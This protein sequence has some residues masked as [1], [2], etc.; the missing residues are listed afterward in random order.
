MDEMSDQPSQPP[1]TDTPAADYLSPFFHALEEAARQAL[2]KTGERVNALHQAIEEESAQVIGQL[3]GVLATLER[4]FSLEGETTQTDPQH[5]SRLAEVVD[6][7]SNLVFRKIRPAM[8]RRL[9]TVAPRRGP[10]LAA[11]ELASRGYAE[12]ARF[13]PEEPQP[14]SPTLEKRLGRIPGAR[15]FLDLLEVSPRQ[16]YIESLP[17]RESLTEHP[18]VRNYAAAHEKAVTQ[19]A[20][21]WRGLRF[22][23]DLASE[24]IFALTEA[25]APREEPV[26]TAAVLADC[27]TLLV[28]TCNDAETKLIAGRN[29]L[30]E[31]L[32]ALPGALEE[33]NRNFIDRIREEFLETR[34]W[35][36]LRRH[37]Q[38]QAR[39]L[40]ADWQG[41]AMSLIDQGKEEVSRSAAGLSQNTNLL[42]NVQT[43]L[44]KGGRVQETFLALTDLPGKETLLEKSAS[45]PR[46]YQ[47]LFTLGPLR[48]REFLVAREEELEDFEEV[49]VRWQEKKACSVAVIGPEGSGKTSLLN[50]FASEFGARGELLELNLDLRLQQDEDLLRIFARWLD[51]E[52]PLA[53]IQELPERILQEPRRV[54][55]VEGGH[56]LGLRTVGGYRM[57]RAFMQLV[58]ATRRHW[59]WIISFRKYPWVLLDHQLGLG[60][61]FTHQ[62]RTL[63]HDQENLQEALLLRQRTSGIE[64]TF[65]PPENQ[66]SDQRP[67]ATQDQLRQ[68][69]FR[70]LFEMTSGNIDAAIYHWLLHVSWD[71]ASSSV[72]ASPLKRF[73]F[74]F[75]RA[76]GRENLF[77]LAEVLN[78]GALAADEYA[79]IFR[80]SVADAANLLDSLVHFNILRIEKSTEGQPTYQLN[81]VFF[82][83]VSA[84]LESMNI[85]H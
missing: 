46:L 57:A 85:L 27:H 37:Y 66:G 74:N 44:G 23:F 76:L 79:Q 64:L 52:E 48:N 82:G 71:A 1:A 53:S 22:H 69:F 60:Q 49:F 72:Q 12:C 36:N 28:E 3:H 24:E 34:R 33:S 61:F 7:Q 78:H 45:L 20:D 73:E 42:R 68:R 29:R 75:L 10:A 58:M 32:L 35:G 14:P 62:I 25:E 17:N 70:D 67:A 47:R 83:P 21:I 51:D 9:K 26:D 16:L 5:I 81:P 6:S 11:L 40:A 77:A 84:T 65:V 54:V 2:G 31:A 55:I 50:S 4:A 56:N 13:L 38:R 59:L 41:K 18:L 63:F 43:L 30:L 8:D 80:R 19:L 39:T 15:L